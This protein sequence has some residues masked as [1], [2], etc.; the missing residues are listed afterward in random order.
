MTIPSKLDRDDQWQRC[1]AFAAKRLEVA[2]A[3]AAGLDAGKF[4]NLDAAAVH[5]LDFAE[6]L[7]RQNGIRAQDAYDKWL[8]GFKAK[9]E[10]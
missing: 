9:G 3:I 8:D 6:A 7:M 10:S 2:K 1:K 4:A 5:A